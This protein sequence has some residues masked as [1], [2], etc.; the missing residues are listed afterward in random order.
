VAFRQRKLR[1]VDSESQ[2]RAIEP[3]KY[4]C[5]CLRRGH[6]GGR[7]AAPQWPG[8]C[9]P[10]GVEE[11]GIGTLGFPRNLGG[12]IFSSS[13]RIGTGWPIPTLQA[14][15]RRRRACGSEHR[16]AGMVPSSEG[17]RARREGSS[18]VGASHSTGEAGE[19][20]PPGP[21]GGKGMLSRRPVGGK[22]GECIGTRSCVNEMPTDRR[23]GTIRCAVW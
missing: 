18:G 4:S 21:C 3:R 16:R 12:P 22:H 10:A 6:S 14:P 9:G 13:S 15:S 2:G 17:N 19:R 23:T 1:S 5:G 20:E 11:Q 8:A 7:A